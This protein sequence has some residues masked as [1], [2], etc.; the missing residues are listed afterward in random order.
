MRGI[1]TCVLGEAWGVAG[2]EYKNQELTEYVATR[3]Y[4][5]PEVILASHEYSKPIDIWGV[6]C[7][8]AE[9]LTGKVLF[10]SDNYI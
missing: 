9:L 2:G 10:K 5:A 7:T 8:F 3:Y 1:L 6:G 4:R